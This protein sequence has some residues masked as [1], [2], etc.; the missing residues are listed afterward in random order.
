MSLG[1][2]YPWFV[3]VYPTAIACGF[4][5]FITLVG[6]F[7]PYSHCF[8]VCFAKRRLAPCDPGIIKPQTLEY[9]LKTSKISCIQ[10]SKASEIFIDLFILSR[11]FSK[12]VSSFFYENIFYSFLFSTGDFARSSLEGDLDRN[13]LKRGTEKLYY[14]Q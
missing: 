4:G 10:N 3:P 11:Y 8:G 5:E 7:S 14:F 1:I 12:P 13:L 9:F 2:S 6:P